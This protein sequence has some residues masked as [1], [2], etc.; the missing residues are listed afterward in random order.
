MPSNIQTERLILRPW[1]EEDLEHFA[2]LNADPRVMEYFPSV[3][4]REESDQL[5]KKIQSKIEKNGWGMWAVSLKE[6]GKFIGFVG[7]NDVDLSFPFAPAVEIGWRLA[8]EAWGK[9]Y[10][11]EGAKEALRYGF[12]KLN[13]NEIVSFTTV[14]N[15]R[16][17]RI[18]EKI[19]MHHAPKDDFDHPKIPEGHPLQRH[20]LYRLKQMAWKNEIVTKN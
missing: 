9:G 2:S 18:M 6:N 20:V 10:A 7:L 11:A 8:Y 3:L 12:E 16:S 5:A 1:R 4:S 17:R 14:Q 13:F 15:L 19:G